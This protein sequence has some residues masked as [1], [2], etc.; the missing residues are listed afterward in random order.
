MCTDMPVM[1]QACFSTCDSSV[2]T[3]SLPLLLPLGLMM[4]QAL[5]FYLTMSVCTSLGL[6]KLV[7]GLARQVEHKEKGRDQ[8]G[9]VALLSKLWVLGV[10][11]YLRVEQEA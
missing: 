2:L 3:Q 6:R 10:Q 4:Y 9:V 5:P 7:A 8:V 1:C 11:G